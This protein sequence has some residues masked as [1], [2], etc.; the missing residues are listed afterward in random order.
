M[1]AAVSAVV[2]SGAQRS[3]TFRHAAPSLIPTLACE[4]MGSTDYYSGN[5]NYG[6]F[7]Y[8]MQH[9]VERAAPRLGD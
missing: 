7:A 2:H 6:H 9:A 8:A 4:T 5:R 1:L 3:P